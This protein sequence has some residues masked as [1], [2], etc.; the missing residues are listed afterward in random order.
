MGYPVQDSGPGQ[1]RLQCVLDQDNVYVVAEEGTK[2][3]GSDET[4]HA[5]S[6]SEGD[7][8]PQA[9]RSLPSARLGLFLS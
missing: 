2:Y 6:K 8:M 9:V 5:I 1:Q 4:A 7:P 3:Y